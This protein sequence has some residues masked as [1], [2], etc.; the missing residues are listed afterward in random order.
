MRPVFL[1]TSTPDVS[2]YLAPDIAS[3]GHSAGSSG[4]SGAMRWALQAE[5][6]AHYDAHPFEF[7]SPADDAAIVQAQPRV[8][9]NFIDNTP[10]LGLRVADVGCGTG[11][12]TKFL[13]ERGFN[14]VAVDVSCHSLECARRR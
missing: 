3:G 8:F 14:V 5:T 4:M 13:L 10:G 11:R 12:E 9:R 6:A 7:L 1:S 2:Q